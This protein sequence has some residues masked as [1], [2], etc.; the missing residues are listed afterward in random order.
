M[1]FNSWLQNL[2][3]ALA[4]GRG[5]RHHR[6]RGSLRAAT[7]RPNLEVLEDRCL[8]SF[9]P[10][11]SFPVDTSPQ[12]V[13]TADFNND[14]Q[15][16]LATTNYD[17]TVSVLLGDGRAGS[18]PRATSPPGRSA[19]SLAVGDFNN[20]GNLDL[21]TLGLALPVDRSEL[22]EVSVL[23]G[24]GDGTFR[25]PVNI[26]LVTN[27]SP[28]SLA[29]GDFNADGNTDLVYTYPTALI[30]YRVPSRC[31]SVTA[32]AASR[33]LGTLRTP[34][35]QH[36]TGWRSPTSTATA[37]PTWSRRTTTTAPSAC[38]WATATALTTPTRAAATSP[39]AR[40]PRGGGR[41]LHRRRHPRPG[42][43]RPDGGHPAR[44]RRR[45]VR[46]PDPPS[47]NG[48]GM[49][50][51]A[52][53]D[54]NGDTQLDVVT[55]DP[56]AGTVSVL[57]GLGDGTLTPPI[58][59]A[60]GSSPRAVA[61]GDFNGDGRPDVAAADRGSNA[62]S[63]LLNDGAWSL[64]PEHRRRL[65]DQRRDGHGGEHRHGRRHLHADPLGRLHRRRDGPLRTRRTAPPR[66]AAT[67]RPRPAT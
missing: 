26:G 30:D 25:P 10:A 15:L 44:P 6:R 32:R 62:V 67:T 66:P 29:V 19:R 55:A 22:P 1:S 48:S 60:A 59:H 17:G 56:G 18:A 51:V 24:N 47:A 41:R 45:H 61:V 49:T 38:C 13:A 40:L 4:P 50:T 64:R 5:Q 57:L 34:R 36:P 23:L 12:A 31:C 42:H 33:S 7:H 54:F 27:G 35:L 39:P 16:D 20:D 65:S 63:V 14:G 2:R 53:A 43:R 21:A 46:P 58:D 8:L 52:A 11:A 28:L 37:S 3:S 9:S